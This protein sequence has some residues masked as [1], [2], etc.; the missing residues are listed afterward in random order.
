M[1]QSGCFPPLL[2]WGPMFAWSLIKGCQGVSASWPGREQGARKG[3]KQPKLGSGCNKLAPTTRRIQIQI[4]S[5]IQIQIQN[6]TKY[7]KKVLNNPNLARVATNGSKNDKTDTNAHTNKYKDKNKDKNTEI[8]TER[9]QTTPSWLRLQQIGSN[10]RAEQANADTET[11]TDTNTNANTDT[12]SATN[13]D[14]N[15][16]EICT[17]AKRPQ[18]GSC[19][20]K[21]ALT[22]SGEQANIFFFA[23]KERKSRQGSKVFRT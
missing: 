11:N 5:Q 6:Q 1:F 21:L 23:Q 18:L 14:T 4:Q 19:C 13:T 15:T 17:A 7:R 2:R 20:Y 12:N 3:A 8:E 22:S 9:V 10:H 16:E